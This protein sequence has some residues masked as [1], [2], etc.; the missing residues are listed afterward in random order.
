MSPAG[1]GVLVVQGV[2]VLEGAVRHG[3]VV[4]PCE[5]LK[6]RC[7]RRAAAPLA[8]ALDGRRELGNS[9]GAH[10]GL[11]AGRF[12][13]AHGRAHGLGAAEGLGECRRCSALGRI[14][15]NE[16]PDARCSRH[17]EEHQKLGRSQAAE[18]PRR[19]KA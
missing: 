15:G 11:A 12:D 10:A 6:R 19:H 18:E 16:V 8:K 1:A 9:R 2:V 7:G 4:A 3:C 17:V 14:H 13:G 5:L